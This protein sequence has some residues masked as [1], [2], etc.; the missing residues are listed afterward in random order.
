[1]QQIDK[2]TDTADVI[3]MSVSNEDV[4][5]FVIGE[6]A[7]VESL[8]RADRTVD[9]YKVI[10]VY[11]IS[12]CVLIRESVASSEK[13]E[14]LLF[15]LTGLLVILNRSQ[16]L[17]YL[18][19]VSFTLELDGLVERFESH[20]SLELVCDGTADIDAACRRIGL[21]SC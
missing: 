13:L 9:D 21:K 16:E 4:D 17:Q 12:A 15:L 8:E 14:H 20:S 5:M 1:M 6:Y 2:K 10:A 11:K 3:T 7:V 19:A 18:E